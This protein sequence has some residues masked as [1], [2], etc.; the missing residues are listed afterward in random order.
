MNIFL[1]P[2]ALYELNHSKNINDIKKA[3]QYFGVPAQNWVYADRDGNIGFTLAGCIPERRGFNGSLPV[4]GA[5]GRYE[6]G[7]CLNTKQLQMQNPPQGWI[8][9]ANEKHSSQFPH[10]IS[11]YYEPPHRSMRIRE[12]L[13][14]KKKVSKKDFQDMQNDTKVL[15]FREFKDALRDVD[16]KSL[17]DFEKEGLDTLLGWDS[18]AHAKGEPA[19]AIFFA[20]FSSLIE[21]LF[22]RDLSKDERNLYLQSRHFSVDALRTFLQ[23]AENRE[24]IISQGLKDALASLQK[25]LGSNMKDWEWGDIHQLTYKHGLGRVSRIL[26]WIFNRGPFPVGGGI[27]SLSP[28]T[29]AFDK[30]YNVTVGD[31][32]RYIMDLS[33]PDLSLRVIPS[34]ISG[35]FLSPHYDD[36]IEMYLKG[37]Y[38]PFVFSREKVNEQ[39]K[40][41]LLLIPSP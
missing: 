10:P 29:F 37:K 26:A 27:F 39:K 32:M 22:T 36:Q 9:S 41:R 2:I 17:S 33:D 35:N 21:N 3:S 15:L 38:R 31:S 1:S 6:W 14:N 40:Y 28:M 34:G 30:P 20:L 5:S 13:D 18:F 16:R 19:A 7:P 23:K 24:D 11:H 4:D 8:A 25:K 12:F